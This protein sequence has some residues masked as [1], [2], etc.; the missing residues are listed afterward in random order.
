LPLA[1]KEFMLQNDRNTLQF[2]KTL[3]KFGKATKF[4][5]MCIEVTNSMDDWG[6]GE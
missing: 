1:G 6:V 2:A 4:I 5:K 3:L